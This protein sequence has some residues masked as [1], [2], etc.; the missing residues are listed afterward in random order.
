MNVFDHFS[1]YTKLPVALEDVAAFVVERTHFVEV[2]AYPRP[3]DPTILQGLCWQFLDKPHNSANHHRR[4]WV[5]Y[6]DKLEPDMARMVICK[7][8]LHLL[9]TALEQA[10]DRD[11]V[12]Q[13]LD[14]IVQ[15][16]ELKSAVQTQSDQMGMLLALAV[17]MPSGAI[18]ELR[19]L[20]ERDAIGHDTLSKLAGVPEHY[21]RFAFSPLWQEALKVIEQYFSVADHEQPAEGN[22]AG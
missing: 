19:P 11:Q 13:L 15:P 4:A 7:E 16:F 18:D 12:G 2:E 8:L 5:L 17:L 22:A 9:D 21:I 20:I 1:A 3:F 14:E 6:S 10:R